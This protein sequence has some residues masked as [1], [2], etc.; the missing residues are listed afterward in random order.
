[1]RYLAIGN[2]AKTIKSDKGGEYLTAIMYLAPADT[3]P[4]VNVCATAELAQGK[5]PCLFTAGRGARAPF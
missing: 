4:G 1:M 5:A 3:V 2:N